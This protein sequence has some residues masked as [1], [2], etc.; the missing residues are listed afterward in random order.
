MDVEIAEEQAENPLPETSAEPNSS[1]DQAFQS[2][3][4]K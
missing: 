4:T 1:V 3:I 2:E